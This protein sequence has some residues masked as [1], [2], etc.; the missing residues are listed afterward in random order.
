MKIA[1]AFVASLAAVYSVQVVTQ[2]NIALD[3]LILAI[4]DLGR[5]IEEFER[6][7]GVRPVFGG[8]H[9]GRG[10]QNALASLGDGPFIE[11]LAPNPKEPNPARP[12]PQNFGALRTLTPNGWALGTT[13][14]AEVATRAVARGLN[15]SPLRPGS[16]TLPD[17][18]RLEW[19]TLN[20]IEPTVRWRPFFIQWA[21][22]A[23]QPSATSPGGCT[24]Q[25][26]EIED[27]NPEPLRTLLAA[28]G[29]DIALKKSDVSRMT[30][31]LRCPKGLVTFR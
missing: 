18:S 15:A 30:I 9:P 3:H 17:G 27:P 7:T 26:I 25:S 21:N 8:V 5:G 19:Q 23:L 16:R 11:I 4:N 29:F 2:R 12:R 20:I 6:M 28:V 1:I 14:L 22:P 24:L 31:V 13:D 10:T